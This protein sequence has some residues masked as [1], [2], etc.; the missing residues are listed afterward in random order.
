MDA[1]PIAPMQGKWDGCKPHCRG[2]H[3]IIFFKNKN[4]KK[5]KKIKI[6]KQRLAVLGQD[7][8]TLVVASEGGLSWFGR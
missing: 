6:K 7:A 1:S 8:S 3:F 2:Y 5:L 4:K